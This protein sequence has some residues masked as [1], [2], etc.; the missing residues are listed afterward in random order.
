VTVIINARIHPVTAPTLERGSILI[1]DGVIQGV[2]ANVATPAG[3]TVIDAAGGDVYPG[4]I[5]ARTTLGL[6][7]PGARGYADTNEMLEFSP[8]LRPTVA[9]HNDS[10]PINVTRAN[11]ITTAAV[12]PAGGILGGQ[13]AVMN[14]DGWTWEESTVR[15]SAGIAFQF[16]T[17]T[18]GGGGDEE[19]PA[20]A[21]S[22]RSYEDLKKARD[23]KLEELERLLAQ[24]RAYAR[25]GSGREKDWVLEALVP[26]VEGQ[27]P[28]FTRAD[29]EADIRDAVAFADRVGVKIVIS[30]G[31][32]A[33]YVAPLLAS[34]N[35]P[36]IYGPVQALP[37]RE[38]VS[39]A[40]PLQAPGLLVKA[41]VKIAIA[42]GDANNARL[43]PYHAGMAVAWGLSHDDAI[44]AMTQNAADILGVG[45]RLGSIAVGKQANLVITK[46]DPLEIRTDVAHVI[47]AGRDVDL[48]NKQH[49]LYARYKT[50]K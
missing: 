5:N 36:V 12:T 17:L 24:A 11:G 50:R 29:S 2:G 42:T 15:P 10:E 45:D 40:A 34:K 19:G 13:I 21:A 35:I 28:L 47:I 27:L 1:R 25:K 49:A 43:L 41:G 22:T 26:I 32:E 8:Q 39:H 16:P 18:R 7:D 33:A 48:E 23:A 31:M 38:D 6:A 14:L 46:G 4:W 20:T 30:G 9:Y 3:A 37:R 44:K